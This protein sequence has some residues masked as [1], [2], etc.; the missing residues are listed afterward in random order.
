MQIVFYHGH[1]CGWRDQ[2]WS[3]YSWAVGALEHSSGGQGEHGGLTPFSGAAK[4]IMAV[5]LEDFLA[6]LVVS[7]KLICPV[8]GSPALLQGCHCALDC[9]N[10]VFESLFGAAPGRLALLQ[11]SIEQLERQSG[12]LHA[13]DMASPSKLHF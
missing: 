13:D 1:G 7:A 11:F 6:C 9:F 4:V 10:T 8:Q 2:F 3:T 5:G 12:G